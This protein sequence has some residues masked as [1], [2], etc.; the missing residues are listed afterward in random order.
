MI[1]DGSTLPNR[2]Q[3][4]AKS[5]QGTLFVL[6]QILILIPDLGCKDAVMSEWLRASMRKMKIYGD[7]GSPCLIPLVGM[8]SP[9]GS[10]LI[11]KE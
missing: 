9:F 2:R 3:S 8:M 5:K 1:V 10:S 4:S 7:N 11:S 6:G